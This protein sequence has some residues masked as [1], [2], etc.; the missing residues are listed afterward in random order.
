MRRKKGISFIFVLL[1]LASLAVMDYPFVA[2]LVNSRN[3]GNV[4]FDYSNTMADTTD[5]EKQRA[6]AAAQEYNVELASGLGRKIENSAEDESDPEYQ[7]LLNLTGDGTMGMIEIPKIHVNLVIYHGTNEETLQK[8]VGHLEG[9]S[10]PVGGN[11]THACISA[12]RGLV[13]KKMF[14]DLDQLREGDVFLLHILNETLCYRVGGIQTVLPD[15]IEPLRIQ[16]NKD[17]V[18]LITCTPYGINTHRLYVEGYRIPYTQEV[19]DEIEE[20]EQQLRLRDW[21][22]V[23][24]SAVLLI[25]LVLLLIRYHK[26]NPASGCPS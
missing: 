11:S 14:T 9:S 5:E 23:F 17:L 25:V 21:W 22:W 3:Q 12:H 15:E 10:L 16:Q 18:T 1:F 6:L 4:A 13:S 8:G 20:K 19:S 26:E 2:R 24:M 7:N